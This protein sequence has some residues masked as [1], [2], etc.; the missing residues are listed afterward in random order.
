MSAAA[1]DSSKPVATGPLLMSGR[2]IKLALGSGARPEGRWSRPVVC[3]VVGDAL[4]VPIGSYEVGLAVLEPPPSSPRSRVVV[5]HARYRILNRS[6]VELHYRSIGGQAGGAL[7]KSGPAASAPF[8]WGDTVPSQ[9]Y[10]QLRVAAPA[11]ATGRAAADGDEGWCGAFAIDVPTEV[12]VALPDASVRERSCLRLIQVTVEAAGPSL[13]GFDAT[14]VALYQIRNDFPHNR[15]LVRQ[16]AARASVGARAAGSTLRG[17]SRRASRCCSSPRR[18]PQP[19]IV[20]DAGDGDDPRRRASSSGRS[21]RRWPESEFALADPADAPAREFELRPEELVVEPKAHRA[22]PTGPVV[23]WTTVE[24]GQA[25][26]VVRAAPVS[27]ND[28]ARSLELQSSFRFSVASLSVS[29][30]DTSRRLELLH[31]RADALTLNAIRRRW[32]T[33]RR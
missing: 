29:L 26:R 16:E 7:G 22:T 5:I 8:H 4:G 2:R 19:T 9:R 1:S 10:L 27:A 11:A 28:D 12:A 20:E 23:M 17:T 14:D 25:T 3:E 18:T 15:L 13:V 33:R 6:G 21:P 31:L 30:V 24:L 32:S